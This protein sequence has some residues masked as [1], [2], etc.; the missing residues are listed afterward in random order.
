MGI[1][2]ASAAPAA[3]VAD[4]AAGMS[5]IA[6]G[7]LVAGPRRTRYL[8]I[9]LMLAGAAWFSADIVGWHARSGSNA[10]PAGA[11]MQLRMLA[12]AGAL[13]TAPLLLHVV[14]SAPGRRSMPEWSRRLVAAGYAATSALAL[15]LVVLRDP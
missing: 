7:L 8:G 11:P 2:Y 15:P 12:T 6:A 5:L 4:L 13:L 9:I 14:A 10:A 3:A 1:T